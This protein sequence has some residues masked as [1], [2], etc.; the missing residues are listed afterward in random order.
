MKKIIAAGDGQRLPIRKLHRAKG[1]GRNPR[2]AVASA[3]QDRQL[4]ESSESL[5]GLTRQSI[6][7][8]KRMDPRVKPAGDGCGSI[9]DTVGDIRT[10]AG[11]EAKPRVGGDIHINAQ[12][13]ACA[14]ARRRNRCPGP[15]FQLQFHLAR[16]GIMRQADRLPN[17]FPEG[18]RF[19]IEGRSGHVS[20]YVEFPDGRHVD[21][22][23]RRRASKQRAKVGR[24]LAR[25]R[26]RQAS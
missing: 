25:G 5:P 6:L 23:I 15:A 3:Q 22:P 4:L 9:A 21:L 11:F 12:R 20:R 8:R 26:G 16:S 10:R 13:S 17:R 2:V 24:R 14:A 18:T 1:L 7:F 19:V